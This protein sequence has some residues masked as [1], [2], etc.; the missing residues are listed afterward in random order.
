V[1]LSDWAM[2]LWGEE[3]GPQGALWEGLSPPRARNPLFRRISPLFRLQRRFSVNT[4][5]LQ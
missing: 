5:N 3:S 1:I 4:L 2:R